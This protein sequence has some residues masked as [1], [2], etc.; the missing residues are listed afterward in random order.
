MRQ[1]FGKWF[2]VSGLLMATPGKALSQSGQNDLRFVDSISTLL[3]EKTVSRDSVY[4]IFLE[5]VGNLEDIERD[6]AFSLLKRDLTGLAPETAFDFTYSLT[7]R[8]GARKA[9]PVWADCIAQIQSLQPIDTLQLTKSWNYYGTSCHSVGDIE[10]A[11]S[12]FRKVIEILPPDK[13]DEELAVAHNNLGAIL[14]THDDP[15]G[16]L[17]HYLKAREI[18]GEL[19]GESHY[20]IGIIGNNIGQVYD[21]LGRY[22][23]QIAEQEKSRDIYLATIGRDHSLT[24][25][26]YIN[27]GIV[28]R[29]TG[30]R[31]KA[32]DAFNEALAIRENTGDKAGVVAAM[33]EIAACIAAFPEIY[34]EEEIIA[35]QRNTIARGVELFDSNNAVLRSVY[36][37]HSLTLLGNDDPWG[38]LYFINKS[39]HVS[40]PS[41][42]LSSNLDVPDH[43]SIKN[44]AFDDVRLLENKGYILQ[45]LFIKN[46]DPAVLDAAIRSY[47][48]GDSIIEILKVEILNGLSRQFLIREAGDF[49][50]NAATSAFS[51]Y[52]LTHARNDLELSITWTEKSRNWDLI[53]GYLLSAESDTTLN[54]EILK[55]IANLRA[56]LPSAHDKA[57][58]TPSDSIQKALDIELQKLKREFPE[59]FRYLYNY[60][61]ESLSSIIEFCKE[62]TAQWLYSMTLSGG[63]SASALITADTVMVHYVEHGMDSISMHARELTTSI[64]ERNW[65]FGHHAHR[66][67]EL[68]FGEMGTALR[69]GSIYF[70]ST[71]LL[72]TVPLDILLETPA[73]DIPVTD[74]HEYYLINRVGFIVLPSATFGITTYNNEKHINS[75]VF[76][77]PAYSDGSLDFTEE[78]ARDASGLLGGK[79][80]AGDI[81]ADDLINSLQEYDLVHFAGHSFTHKDDLDSIFMLIGSGGDTLYLPQL[82][83]LQSST[84]L[85]VLSS[86]RSAIGK[87]SYEGNISLTYGLALAGTPSVISSIWPASD[88][89]TGGIFGGF[90]RE[91]KAGTHSSESLRRAKLQY[92]QTAPGPARHPWYWANWVHNG[93]P[94]KYRKPNTNLLMAVLGIGLLVVVIFFFRRFY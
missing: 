84:R 90:Y 13:I 68:I 88:R 15:G 55:T 40:Y 48:L 66:L 42:T 24:G 23:E 43:A 78:E 76:I 41:F 67:Y 69:D 70:S 94:V 31:E 57:A 37:N 9:I 4:M 49:Y 16:A 60:R 21:K 91:L 19:L 65:N 6:S 18:F 36:N 45:K 52:H 61:V 10:Q 17:P 44:P 83:N 8:L 86:C 1:S 34:S 59:Y 64:Q 33:S 58:T 82:F 53:S 74:W 75:S 79:F 3:E 92:L 54:H 47:T 39:I 46:G 50:I 14:N 11:K 38:A 80:I 32:L 89:E 51:R 35:A 85:A 25:N 12:C 28:Y 77:S 81:K 29:K 20:Y 71:G 62:Q 72:Q 87:G 56:Q 73:T 30:Q 2:V 5:K 63:S 93:H 7:S 27:L 22:E 26:V